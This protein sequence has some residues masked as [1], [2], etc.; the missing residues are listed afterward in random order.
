[1]KSLDDLL[2]CRYWMRK[3]ALEEPIDVARRINPQSAVEIITWIMNPAGAQTRHT[4]FRVDSRSH[5]ILFMISRVFS[6][7]FTFP[8]IA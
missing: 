5:L 7:P 4:P 1:M 3:R 8:I 6:W 2:E